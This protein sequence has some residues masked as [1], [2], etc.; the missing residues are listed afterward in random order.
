MK[1][2]EDIKKVLESEYYARDGTMP[3]DEMTW[4]N[5]A[6]WIEALEYVLEITHDKSKDIN[7]IIEGAN[8]ETIAR[9]LKRLS[10]ECGFGRKDYVIDSKN[11]SIYNGGVDTSQ[12]CFA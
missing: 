6:G 10:K 11:D 9:A 5:N 12:E 7:H 2:K 8:N 3:M 4:A 1:S